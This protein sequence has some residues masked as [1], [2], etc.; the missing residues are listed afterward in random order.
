MEECVMKSV[1]AGDRAGGVA[2]ARQPSFKKDFCPCG[3]RHLVHT[4]PTTILKRKVRSTEGLAKEE[5]KRRSSRWSVKPAPAEVETK[6]KKAAGK[7]KSSDKKVQTKGRRGAKG[8]QAEVAN[9]EMKTYLQKN[10]ETENE[11]HPASDE[12]GEKSQSLLLFLRA[13]GP[14]SCRIHSWADLHPPP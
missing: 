12:A 8:K 6:P 10:G 7:D 9:Q 13:V 4:C 14:S 3:C 11:E 2:V 5:P 1:D